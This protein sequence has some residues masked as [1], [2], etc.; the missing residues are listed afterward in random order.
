MCTTYS[1]F[2]TVSIYISPT[3][4]WAA[5]R[6]TSAFVKLIP[7]TGPEIVRFAHPKAITKYARHDDVL[8]SAS[9]SEIRHWAAFNLSVDMVGYQKLMLF[10]ND[11]TIWS[12]SAALTYGYIID[13]LILIGSRDC[14]RW[15]I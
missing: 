9:P 13:G 3:A 6:S 15:K 10:P 12:I 5:R 14:S 11:L 4:R 8:S 7:E 1:F 2:R